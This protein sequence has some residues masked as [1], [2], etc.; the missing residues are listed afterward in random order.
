MRRCVLR[1]LPDSTANASKSQGVSHVKL[2]KHN[3][4]YWLQ[5]DR[6]VA[7]DD[8]SAAN[9]LAGLYSVQMAPTQEGGA[10][11]LS[12]VQAAEAGRV[13]Q[14][15]APVEQG[16]PPRAV[17]PDDVG[18]VSEGETNSEKAHTTTAIHSR[19]H[20][21]TAGSLVSSMRVWKSR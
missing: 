13:S 20:A 4:T 1:S 18:N 19:A 3:G 17:E 16:Q 6:R 7:V 5:A 11:S 12:D 14:E 15:A 9:A 8:K 2:K 21:R 10:P